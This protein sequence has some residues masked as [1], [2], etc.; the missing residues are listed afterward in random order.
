[1]QFVKQIVDERILRDLERQQTTFLL[2]KQPF[3]DIPVAHAYDKY[4][5]P[6]ILFVPIFKINLHGCNRQANFGG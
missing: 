5:G 6:I 3:Q 4:H 1:M 2:A